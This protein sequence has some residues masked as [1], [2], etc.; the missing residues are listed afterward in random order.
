VAA[1]GS[2]ADVRCDA[3]AAK[4]EVWL[5]DER[6]FIRQCVQGDVSV[7]DFLRLRDQTK[8]AAERLL[9]PGRVLVLFDARGTGKASPA[10]RRAMIGEVGSVHR[11]AFFGATRIGRVI[12]RFMLVWAGKHK[13]GVFRDEQEAIAWLM[14]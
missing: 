14:S 11:I 13:I 5:D 7:D 1:R 8:L 2:L 9:D 3:M 4:I 12:A 6:R 10:A